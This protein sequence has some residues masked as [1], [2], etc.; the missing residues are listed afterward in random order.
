MKRIH[1]V[2]LIL[3][4]FANA[5]VADSKIVVTI[6]PIH[7][8][9]ASVTDGFDVPELLIG[10]AN[11]VHG[12]QVTPSNARSLENA[13]IVFWISP[14]LESTLTPSI[15]NLSEETTVIEVGMM[16]GLKLYETRESPNGHDHGHG[17]GHEEEHG[18]DDGHEEEH[19]SEHDDGHEEEHHSDADEH[20]G[21]DDGHGHGRYDM[22]V[23]L[24]I[25]N[26]KAIT[27]EAAEQLV[28]VYPQHEALFVSNMNKTLQKL[29]AS[30]VE[31]RSLSSSF[32]SSPY[33]VFHDAYQYFEKMLGLNN[34]GTVTVN[35][36][37]SPGA[38]R[39]LELRELISETG[40]TCAFKEPQFSPRALEVIGEGTD[41]QIG[42]M[43]PLGADV[44][45]GPNAYFQ[46]LRNLA[47]SLKDCLG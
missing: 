45:P 18:H 47:N 14:S 9:V 17:G 27:E 31:V 46:I 6:N 38:K 39:L 21:H 28:Q 11:S 20:H 19:H 15:S 2:L 16:H 25:E 3:V 44:E 34:V 7:S 22:H 43:D 29:D 30:E 26:A 24:D 10:G 40:A 37:Y 8:L 23:W 12:Y 36:E 13:D 32:A 41:L 33:V 35:P 4:A 42:T 5:A 1:L